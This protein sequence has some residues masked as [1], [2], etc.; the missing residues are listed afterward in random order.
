MTEGTK[1]T[2]QKPIQKM[3]KGRGK[4]ESHLLIYG[5]VAK[6]QIFTKLLMRIIVIEERKLLQRKK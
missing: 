6:R 5:F 3:E 1:S 2:T 4:I